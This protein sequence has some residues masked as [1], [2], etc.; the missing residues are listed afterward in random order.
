MEIAFHL[1]N[2]ADA[3]DDDKKQYFHDDYDSRHVL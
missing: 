3:A 1:L 2:M